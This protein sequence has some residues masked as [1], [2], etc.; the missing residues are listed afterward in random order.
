[1][2]REPTRWG[3]RDC[4]R[5]FVQESYQL[6]PVCPHCG[7]TWKPEAFRESPKKAKPPDEPLVA[8]VFAALAMGFGVS[9]LFLLPILFA[10]LG[11]VCALVTA[12]VGRSVLFRILAAV[13]AVVCLV[14][15]AGVAQR[16]YDA[17]DRLAL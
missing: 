11:F 4:G 2:T 5:L 3:C 8:V 10:P 14:I 7:H 15:A 6:Y 13:F 1:M 17:F 16:L 9:S 12:C